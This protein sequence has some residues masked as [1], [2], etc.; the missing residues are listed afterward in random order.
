[1]I[2]KLYEKVVRFIKEEYKFII[3]CLVILIVGL[4]PLPIRL[5]MGGWIINLEDRIEIENEYK[6]NGSFNLA[7]VRES[8]ATIPT[9]LLSFVTNWDRVKISDV[10]LDENDNTKDMWKREQ[11]YLKE[12]SDNAIINAYKLAGEKIAINKEVFQILYI[13]LK[14][15]TNLMIGDEIIS[16]DGNVINNYDDIGNVVANKNIGD[17]VNILINRDD[18]EKECYAI[19]K[20]YDGEKKI[21][22][23]M[24]KLYD[25]DIERDI[26]L[27][28][29]NREGGSSGGFML[30]LA[31]YNRLI[32][33]DI[34]KGL[35]IVG[36]GTI[37]S[38]G[39]VGEIGGVKYKLKGAVKNKADIFFV[40]EAN[41]LEAMNE[42]DEHGYKI[43]IV[44]VYTLK[45]AINYLE[46]R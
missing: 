31:I 10:K 21:G 37:D 22:I 12:A 9:Y 6:E 1:M 4:F 16:I 15:E 42:K 13:D 29:S 45:D 32:E 30:S 27:K 23:S 17:K 41:Y 43:D 2:N 33:K 24:L 44:K 25:Y 11:L 36:T 3:L 26:D 5:Y 28:F 38:L 46:S 39:N 34:T 20:D 7:Y 35:K 14:A 40:P 18:K 8:R 19:I